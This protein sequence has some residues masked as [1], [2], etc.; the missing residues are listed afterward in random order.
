MRVL[1]MDRTTALIVAIA[2]IVG[3]VILFVVSFILYRK[4][5]P[6]KGCEHLKVD[7]SSCKS[8]GEV[9]CDL[10]AEYHDETTNKPDDKEA[11]K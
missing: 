2:I 7:E 6:P 10:Y 11:K 5:P 3:L 4:T 8:C 9:G 1:T